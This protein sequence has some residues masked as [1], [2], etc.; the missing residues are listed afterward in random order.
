[1]Y[2]RYDLPVLTLQKGIKFQ[3][4]NINKKSLILKT[5]KNSCCDW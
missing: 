4:K 2:Q 1:M 3:K 5:Y